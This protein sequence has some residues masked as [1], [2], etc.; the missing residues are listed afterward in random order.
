MVKNFTSN[1]SYECTQ[2]VVKCKNVLKAGKMR[3]SCN[4]KIREVH[5]T[6][7]EGVALRDHQE[8]CKVSQCALRFYLGN[9]D[10]QPTLSYYTLQIYYRRAC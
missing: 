3:S 5:F 9:S 10:A 4:T 8:Y 2:H 6:L 7:H 1:I